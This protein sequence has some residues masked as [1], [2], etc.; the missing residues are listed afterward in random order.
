[1]AHISSPYES[2]MSSEAFDDRNFYVHSCTNV[3]CEQWQTSLS[4]MK[5]GH[6][7]SHQIHL[8]SMWFKSKKGED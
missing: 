5:E 6:T 3:L 8:I 7:S 4:F 1:M 2:C